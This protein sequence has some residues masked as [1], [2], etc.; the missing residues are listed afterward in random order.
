VLRLTVAGY[1]PEDSSHSRAL[2]LFR[3]RLEEIA[4]DIVVEIVWDIV[5]MGRPVGDLIGLVERG[6][7]T[8]CYLSTS[9]LTDR[10]SELALMDTPFRFEDLASAHRTLDGSAGSIL[11]E[12][13]SKA[14]GLEVL[15]YWDNGFRHLTNRLR[16]VR[17]P[18]DCSGMR[19]RVQPSVIH[20]RMI[21]LW[22]AVPVPTD[23]KDG[24]DLIASGGVDA[25]ENPLA[26][27]VA[28]G[29]E[30]H[31]RHVSLTGH[32]YG[33]RGLYANQD[34]VRGWSSV[35]RRAIE[36]ALRDAIAWQRV[37]AAEEEAA[38][39]NSL[40]RNGVEVVELT[41]SERAEFS[42]AVAPLRADVDAQLP[43]EL[44]EAVT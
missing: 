7:F 37:A 1:A 9:Y 30:G 26:N 32:V 39:L 10:V 35:S 15:G 33:A 43:Q 14:T 5:D 24:I 34:A 29:I 42:A 40:R 21:E 16:D 4:P 27:T 3:R 20:E 19:I 13:T 28:Y 6:D 18:E 8:L 25:Q 36:E 2:D 11:S 22:G 17:R 31:H 23:L 41:D 44:L 38:I 12:A